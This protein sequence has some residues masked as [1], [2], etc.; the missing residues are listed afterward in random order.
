MARRRIGQENLAFTA[1]ERG[2]NAG[3]DALATAIHWAPLAR[4][5]D[6]VDAATARGEAAWPPLALFKASLL[7]LCYDRCDVELAQALDD[8]ASFRRFGGVALSEPTPERTAF[9][10]L[11]CAL[12]A[13]GLDA[14]LYKAVLRQ[15]EAKKL[16]ACTGTLIHDTVLRESR[17]DDAEAGWNADRWRALRR[18]RSAPRC[19]LGLSKPTHTD[20]AEGRA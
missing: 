1:A 18:A 12:V 5:L 19:R 4:V 2:G 17:S 10:R 15:F 20:L 11:R 8:R 9:V 6:E 7:R 16:V 13:R 14:T 3:L